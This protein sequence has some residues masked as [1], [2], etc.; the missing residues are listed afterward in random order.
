MMWHIKINF[1]IYT[2]FHSGLQSLSSE[3]FTAVIKDRKKDT[4][5]G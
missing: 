4:E 5:S 2:L 3:L 1:K